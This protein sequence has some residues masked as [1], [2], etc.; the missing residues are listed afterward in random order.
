MV[1]KIAMWAG[2]VLAVM[3]VLGVVIQVVD[4]E[5]TKRR[6]EESEQRAAERAEKRQAAKAKSSSPSGAT[7]AGGLAAIDLANAG[8]LKPNAEQVNA[9]ARRSATQMEVPQDE[10]S[11]FVREFT[12]GFWVG[13]KTANQ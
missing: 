4:P 8:G 7:I 12:H 1:K 11:R 5:G 3:F 6:R 2:V 10:R 9:L 13:W